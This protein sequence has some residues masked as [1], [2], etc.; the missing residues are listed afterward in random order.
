MKYT[1]NHPEN[2][3]NPL[4]CFYTAFFQLIIFLIIEVVNIIVLFTKP[5]VIKSLNAFTT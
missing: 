4:S 1:N 5:D 3:A 2:F